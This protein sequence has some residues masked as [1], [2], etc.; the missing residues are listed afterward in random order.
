MK[1]PSLFIYSTPMLLLWFF[2]ELVREQKWLF[3]LAKKI[4]NKPN[5][6]II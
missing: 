1:K 2:L 3:Q 6:N 5:Y 4:N